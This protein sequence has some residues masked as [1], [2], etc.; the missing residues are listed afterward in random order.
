MELRLDRFL[1]GG[2]HR[3]FSDEGFPAVRFTE[4]RENFGHQHQHVRIENG[5]E[6]GDLLKFEN[7]NYI[8]QVARLNIATLATLAMSPGMPQQVRVLTSNLDNDTILRSESPKSCSGNLSYQIVWRET[9]VNDWQYAA[10]A[11]DFPDQVPNS[12]RLLISKDNVFFGVRA[13]TSKGICS[14]VVA[15]VP[16]RER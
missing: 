13:C 16:G 15:P 5:K 7:F 2:D 8:A 10:D 11:K 14:Q 3:S 9:A 4:W 12:V 1:R 6:Y